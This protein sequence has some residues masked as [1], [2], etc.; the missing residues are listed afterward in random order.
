MKK[1]SLILS[2]FVFSSL[3]YAS[4]EKVPE[5]SFHRKILKP[6]KMGDTHKKKLCI[7]S[8][9]IQ[10]ALQEKETLKNNLLKT[11]CKINRKRRKN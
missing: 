2:V 8:K 4:N 7:S 6:H 5:K 9:A 1:I 3:T 10:K 11:N